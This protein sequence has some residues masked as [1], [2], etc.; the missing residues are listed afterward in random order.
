[1]LDFFGTFNF[2]P[3]SKLGRAGS[4]ISMRGEVF[5]A[6]ILDCEICF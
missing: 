1:M 5:G 2:R 4:K 6:I 3:H